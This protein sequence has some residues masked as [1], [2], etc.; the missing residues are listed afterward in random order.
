LGIGAIGFVL[1]NENGT[2]PRNF[3]VFP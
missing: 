3:V 2:P 1:S